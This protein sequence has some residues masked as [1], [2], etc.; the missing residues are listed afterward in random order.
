MVSPGYKITL[1]STSYLYSTLT[2]LKGEGFQTTLKFLL[3]YITRQRITCILKSYSAFRVTVLSLFYRSQRFGSIP[4]FSTNSVCV[5]PAFK[6]YCFIPT[7]NSKQTTTVKS[8]QTYS[9]LVW[10]VRPRHEGSSTPLW[11]WQVLSRMGHY[12]ERWVAGTS[13]QVCSYMYIPIYVHKY[14]HGFPAPTAFLLSS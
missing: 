9:A 4:F 1:K 14:F 10:T 11:T 7:D 6:L 3:P 12:Q 2:L 8:P 13:I 5:W